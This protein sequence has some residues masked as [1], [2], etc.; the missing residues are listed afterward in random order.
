MARNVSFNFAYIVLA[1]IVVLMSA[2][3]IPAAERPN[4]VWIV[5]ED[6]SPNLGCYGDPVAITPNLDNLAR[7]S[8]RF[9]RAFTHAPVC[10]PSRSGL[11][12]GQY[13]VTMGSHHMRSKL[14][15]PPPMFPQML[16]KA[17]YRV[18]WPGKTDF[19]F[20]APKGW[21]TSTEDWTK[22]PELLDGDTPFFAY[23]NIGIT[24]ESKARSTAAEHAKITHRLKSNEFIDPKKVLLP[25]YWPDNEAVRKNV[26]MYHEN[27]TAM[28]Y[29]VGDILKMLDDRKLRDNTIV[30][31]FGDHGWGLPRGKRWCY[32]SGT[33]VPLLIRWPGTIAKQSVREDLVCFL[34]FAPTALSLAGAAVPKEMQGRV[35][36][37]EKTQPAP[38]YVFSCRDRMD[39]AVD[40]I[41]SVRGERFRYVK[42]FHPELPYAQWINYLDEMPIM[43]EWRRLAFEGKLNDV[44][45]AFFARTKPEEELYD[46]QADPH[47]TVNLA[48]KPEHAGTLKE[49]R[50]ALEK[51]IVD[52][53]D[54]G[55]VPERDLIQRG[56][57]KNVLDGEYEERVKKHPKTSPVP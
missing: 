49:M 2:G 26:A 36:L 10:A 50:E 56:V 42:N 55:A 24:H 14:T 39:E 44:Q 34:D 15:S 3:L 53:K 41:R 45:K 22:K 11:I 33:R 27:I 37:G 31:F 57:V 28:D 21:A 17:G 9:T 19:N 1:A 30:F 54:Q 23:H 7:E 29:I 51:W 5:S 8:V 48:A 18:F 4:I 16:Q 35:M 25:P 6:I 47:E 38:K 40:R 20:D 32:D 52:V 13:P 12:T 43:K 46:L